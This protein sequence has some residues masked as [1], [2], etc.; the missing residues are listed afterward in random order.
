MATVNQ[1]L[2]NLCRQQKEQQRQRVVDSI[3]NN[4]TRKR[5]YDVDVY[6]SS[7]IYDHPILLSRVAPT[8]VGTQPLEERNTRARAVALYRVQLEKLKNEIPVPTQEISSI[9]TALST[10]REVFTSEEFEYIPRLSENQQLDEF[11]E[12]LI[13]ASFNIKKM[14]NSD[15]Y[16]FIKFMGDRMYNYLRSPCVWL[17]LTTEWLNTFTMCFLIY[18]KNTY[19]ITSC[20]FVHEDVYNPPKL[21][22]IEIKYFCSYIDQ[23]K[24]EQVLPLD[25]LYPYKGLGNQLMDKLQARLRVT[26]R[27]ELGQDAQTELRLISSNRGQNFYKKKGFEQRNGSV[28]FT[29]IYKKYLKYKDKYLKLKALISNL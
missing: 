8:I 4:F 5:Q 18:R 14:S 2:K 13:F 28:Y 11:K 27:N 25:K 23:I 19:E 29:K 9:I 21:K 20:G 6:N 26:T 12:T 15:K 3:N 16:N 22:K 7:P 1:S 24:D 17:R 10:N